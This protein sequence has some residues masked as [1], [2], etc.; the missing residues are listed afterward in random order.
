MQRIQDLKSQAVR[1]AESS[2]TCYQCAGEM[3]SSIA[4]LCIECALGTWHESPQLANQEFPIPPDDVPELAFT[5]AVQ[6]A[7]GA[8][9][10]DLITALL[11]HAKQNP[12]RYTAT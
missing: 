12:T 2:T 11:E 4:G 9:D 1:P 7:L 5:R 3:P 6:H 8:L 10:P